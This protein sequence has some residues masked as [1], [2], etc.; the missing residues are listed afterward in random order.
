[1]RVKSVFMLAALAATT[2]AAA[3]AATCVDVY[4]KCLN[5]T[6]DTS[7]ITRYLADLECAARYV[8]C[9]RKAVV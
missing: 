6:W 8:G 9:V 2:P 3:D 1:M 7:G 5:D 4:Y